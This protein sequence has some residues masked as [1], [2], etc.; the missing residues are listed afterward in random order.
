VVGFGIN[1]GVTNYMTVD[2]AVSAWNRVEASHPTI[3]G[4]FVWQIHTDEPQGWVF[5]NR[6]GPLIMQ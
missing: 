3:R 1:P 2:Q 4:G 6:L 5:P